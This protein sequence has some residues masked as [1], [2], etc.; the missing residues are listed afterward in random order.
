M[1][2]LELMVCVLT[3]NA[4]EYSNSTI[5]VLYS[6]VECLRL[7]KVIKKNN[8]LMIFKV[9]NENR[10]MFKIQEPCHFL[11]IYLVTLDTFFH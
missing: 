9:N 1:D 8:R 10:D 11:L 3:S 6:C 4:S 2:Y 5:K 7:P